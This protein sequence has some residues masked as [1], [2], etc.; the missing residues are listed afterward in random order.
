VGIDRERRA[1]LAAN[2]QLEQQLYDNWIAV[3]ERE[4]SSNQDIG[5]ASDLLAK[6]PEHLRGWEWHYLMRL[7]DGGRP[8]LD[9]HKSGLWMVAYSPDGRKVATAS[10]DGT[11][12]VWDVATGRVLREF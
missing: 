5:L 2:R 1:A 10:I 9:Q 7:R 3:A 11:A 4:I 6:C 12:K 8:A